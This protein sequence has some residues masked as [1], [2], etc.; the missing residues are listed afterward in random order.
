MSLVSLVDSAISAP[1]EVTKCLVASYNSTI[2]SMRTCI[3]ICHTSG[4]SLMHITADRCA[5]KQVQL[6]IREGRS[7]GGAQRPA[8]NGAAAGGAVGPGRR[9][10]SAANG[11]APLLPEGAEAALLYVRFRAAA[12]PGLKGGNIDL[13][14]TRLS[15]RPPPYVLCTT[16][17]DCHMPT[18]QVNRIFNSDNGSET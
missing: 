9:D 6:A 13:H 8:Q 1:H 18:A 4:A 17:R 14:L 12:E 5:H 11:A 2:S 3:P 7:G 15:C 10:A 16:D